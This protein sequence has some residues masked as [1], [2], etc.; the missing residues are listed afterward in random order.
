RGYL[1]TLAQIR[2]GGRTTFYN[3]TCESQLEVTEDEYN[4]KSTMGA[5]DG[6]LSTPHCTKGFP[7]EDLESKFSAE[8]HQKHSMG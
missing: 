4:V 6:G 2:Q 1:F 8:V 7:E 3:K 5:V